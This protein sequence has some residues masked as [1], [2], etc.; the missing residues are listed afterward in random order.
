MSSY[1]ACQGLSAGRCAQLSWA[2][3]NPGAESTTCSAQEWRDTGE[4]FSALQQ[5][6]GAAATQSHCCMWADVGVTVC[7]EVWA[8]VQVNVWAEQKIQ[9]ECSGRGAAGR[10]Q[11]TAKAANSNSWTSTHQLQP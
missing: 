6:V 2:H 11:H 8:A 3:V 1:R 5:Q 4:V 10:S 7:V 9:L